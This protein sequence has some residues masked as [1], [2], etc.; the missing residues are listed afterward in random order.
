MAKRNGKRIAVLNLLVY[1]D[2]TAAPKSQV[3]KEC[4][5]LKLIHASVINKI[6][7]CILND[8]YVS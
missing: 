1:R 8:N 6:P 3:N 7:N 2:A 4:F 5:S